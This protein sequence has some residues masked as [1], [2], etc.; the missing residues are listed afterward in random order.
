LQ[1]VKVLAVI[2]N[3]ANA[4]NDFFEIVVN[5]NLLLNIFEY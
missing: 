4:I 3:I 2:K 1:A 5:I